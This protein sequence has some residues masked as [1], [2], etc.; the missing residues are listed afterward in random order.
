MKK[1]L[2]STFI[3]ISVLL[4]NH[5]AAFGQTNE[6]NC[7]WIGGMIGCNL[8]SSDC[9]IGYGADCA[10][11]TSATCES[12]PHGCV[13]TSECIAAVHDCIEDEYVCDHMFPALSCPY[14]FI[15][16]E[17][18]ESCHIPPTPPEPSPE[19]DC[20]PDVGSCLWDEIECESP[21]Y[22]DYDYDCVAPGDIC[23]VYVAPTDPDCESACT[24][25]AYP[26]SHCGNFGSADE[27]LCDRPPYPNTLLDCYVG[28]IIYDC[29]CCRS[30]VIIE[31]RPALDPMCGQGI[32]TA[33]GCI[34]LGD[35]NSLIAFFLGWGIGIGGGISFLL[36]LY[37]GFQITTSAGDPQKLQAGKEL[38]TAAIAGIIMLIFSIFLLELIGVRIL[39]LPGF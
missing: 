12:N 31:E 25:P 36:I 10:S 17:A 14:G 11:L 6:Y 39:R 38:L 29:Y 8:A 2:L 4:V 13:L 23:C 3:A 32:N 34:P 18:D 20:E 5:N 28:D 35:I 9:D 24:N 37:A 15:C 33:I 1:I 30:A 7:E 27:T 26:E 21:S 22:V 16:V 19:P